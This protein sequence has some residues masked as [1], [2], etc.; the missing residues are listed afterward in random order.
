MQL[1]LITECEPVHKN[2]EY[3]FIQNKHRYDVYIDHFSAEDG[4]SSFSELLVSIYE[5]TTQN[6]NTAKRNTTQHS[7]VTSLISIA[8]FAKCWQNLMLAC[9]S[10]RCIST[11]CNFPCI[12]ISSGTYACW[13][14]STWT[15][16]VYNGN[17]HKQ[18]EAFHFML[19]QFPVIFL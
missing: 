5:S 2:M 10:R 13:S 17:K 3:T 8:N 7:A 12:A 4:Q 19:I 14:N 18:A 9:S 1:A 11:F 15:V 6:N 16:S